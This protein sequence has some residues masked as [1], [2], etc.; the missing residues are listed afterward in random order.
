MGKVSVPMIH[1]R[2]MIGVCQ[3]K[4]AVTPSQ[5]LGNEGGENHQEMELWGAY[6]HSQKTLSERQTLILKDQGSTFFSKIF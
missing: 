5:R 2:L 3:R 6:M 1:R 4:A